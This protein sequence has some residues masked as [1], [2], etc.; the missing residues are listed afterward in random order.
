[1]ASQVGEIQAMRLH[2]T[3]LLLLLGNVIVL[4]VEEP[5]VKAF[6]D[7]NATAQ[8]LTLEQPQLLKHG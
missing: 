2:A 7:R 1:M 3:E 8:S 4:A 5:L 6:S